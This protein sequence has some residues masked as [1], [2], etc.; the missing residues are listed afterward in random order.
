MRVYEQNG[1]WY[2]ELM[3]RGKRYHRAVPEATNQK[4][5]T[6]YL[7]AFRT[8][9]LRGKLDLVEDVG[10]ELFGKIVDDYIQYAYTNLKSTDTVIPIAKKFKEKWGRKQVRDITPILI[11]KY[12]SGRLA[13]VYYQKEVD[14]K[15]IIKHISPATVNREL[16]VLSK[17]L[18]IAIDNKKLRDNPV[19][20]VEKLKVTN[21]L[22]RHLSAEEQKRFIQF[23]NH[24]YS[25]M[26]ASV[27]DIRKITKKFQNYSYDHVRDIALISLNTGFRLNEVLNLTWDCVDLASN[28][29]CALNTKNGLKNEVPMNRTVKNILVRLE[30]KRGENKYVFTNPETATR[31]YNIDRSFRTVCKMANIKDFRFHD[32]RHTF[33]SRAIANRTPVPVLQSILNHKNIKT[34]MRYVHNT[35]EQKMNAVSTL[36]NIY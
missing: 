12:K 27:D 23:C 2:F 25:Y 13:E 21:K 30:Q 17:I 24:D 15:L 36:D 31:Y 22:E 3:I 20:K 5:A 32:T 10:K 7:Q 33:A 6:T 28:I 35:F 18:N 9:L 14:G 1:R 8:D 26:N 4:E 16:G 19:A 29:V 34:T 11:E